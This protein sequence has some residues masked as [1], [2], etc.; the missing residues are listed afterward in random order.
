MHRVLRTRAE[1]LARFATALRHQDPT[2][3]SRSF[4]LAGGHVVLWGAGMYVNRAIAIGLERAMTVDEFELLEAACAEAGLDAAIETSPATRPEVVAVARS[5]GYVGGT[6][7]LVHRRRLDD[8]DALTGDRSVV[9]ESAADQLAV[10]QETSALGWG[11]ADGPARRA[12]DAF[13]AAAA[14]V[15][16]EGFVVARD[17]GDGRPVGCATVTITDGIATLAAMATIPTE[18]GRGVQSALIRHRLLL[19]RAGGCDVATTT[20]V[21]GGPSDRNLRRHGFVPWFEIATLVRGR[22]AGIAGSVASPGC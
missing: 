14:S 3:Q 17:A 11:H 22:V 19:A 9:V 5:R 1:D 2:R 7:V 4:E 6:S 10:W 21:P 15:D 13:A 12:S 16:G 20:A 18:R 8:L